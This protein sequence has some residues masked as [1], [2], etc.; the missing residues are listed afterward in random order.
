[1]ELDSESDCQFGGSS[2]VGFLEALG[3]C[4][5]GDKEAVPGVIVLCQD[6]IDN[7][8]VVRPQLYSASTMMREGDHTASVY[9]TPAP[10]SGHASAPPHTGDTSKPP[11]LGCKRCFGQ[12]GSF[13]GGDVDSKVQSPSKAV[14]C[15]AWTAGV[16][17]GVFTARNTASRS[18]RNGWTPLITTRYG[19]WCW[20]HTFRG[21]QR[22]GS[23][24]R[25]P[26]S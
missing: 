24:S 13:F 25:L 5:V 18:S 12:S 8:C 15:G 3:G 11:C 7:A 10:D 2:D 16:A 21:W 6:N 19:V 20:R 17:G 1:M 23:T 26:W 9:S 4:E 22:V 14:A